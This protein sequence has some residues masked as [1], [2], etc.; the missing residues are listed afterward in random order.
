ML[1]PFCGADAVFS[2]HHGRKVGGTL[3][4]VAGAAGGVTEALTGARIGAAVG[5]FVGPAGSIAS[6]ST[7]SMT[8]NA[9]AAAATS[10]ARSDHLAA[11][12]LHSNF[13]PPPLRLP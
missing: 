13:P 9:F 5:S 3:G 7:F 10:P 6:I 12:L 1:C 4:A 2:K 11:R 8:T